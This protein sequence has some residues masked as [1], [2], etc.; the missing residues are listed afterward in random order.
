MAIWSEPRPTRKARSADALRKAGQDPWVLCAVARLFW[1]ERKIEKARDW[2]GR[3]AAASEQPADT[4]GDVWAWWLK[5]ERQHG[6]KVRG[7]SPLHSGSYV[8]DRRPLSFFFA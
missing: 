5:F 2:F 3:A 7:V 1:T 4:W 6:T 8:A